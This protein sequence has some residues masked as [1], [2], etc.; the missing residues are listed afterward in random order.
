MIIQ[1]TQGD[2]LKSLVIPEGWQKARITKLE[3]KTSSGGN[4]TNFW[5]EFSIEEGEFK[6]KSVEITYNT[7]SNARN[8]LGNLHMAPYQE[9]I[10]VYCA[11]NRCDK[12]KEGFE[13]DTDDLL[14]KNLNVLFG[15]VAV[16]GQETNVVNNYEPYGDVQKGLTF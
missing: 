7:K 9:L 8:M 15:K 6:G 5:T 4:S 2:V 3:A 13:F 14:G 1:M 11:V 10:Q 12:P 16:E